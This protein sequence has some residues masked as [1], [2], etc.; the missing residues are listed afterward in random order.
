ME[1]SVIEPLPIP[2]KRNE[3]ND[4]VYCLFGLTKDEIRL[5]EEETKYA[6]GEA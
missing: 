1:R 5:I 3:M 6:Y 4:R 2:V